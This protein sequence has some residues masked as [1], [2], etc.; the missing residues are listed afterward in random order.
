M[1][2]EAF[3]AWHALTSTWE[4]IEEQQQQADSAYFFY[5][6]HPKRSYKILCP[7]ITNSYTYLAMRYKD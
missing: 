1:E 4:V 7:Y 5:L 2:I 6:V 3:E